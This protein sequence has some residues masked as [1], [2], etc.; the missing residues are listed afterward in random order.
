MNRLQQLAGLNEAE[1]IS[2]LTEPTADTKPSK[3]KGSINFQLFQDLNIPGYNES[4]FKTTIGKVKG[5]GILNMNDNKIL[6]N[7]MTALIKTSDDALLGKIF[8]NLKQIEAI[9]TK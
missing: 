7:T 1:A 3:V 6:A 4:S 9:K 8:A 2:S 5:G